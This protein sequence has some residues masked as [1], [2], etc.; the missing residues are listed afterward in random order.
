[1]SSR[2]TI[3]LVLAVWAVVA[4]V[5]AIYFATREAPTASPP[6]PSGSSV[7]PDH[8]AGPAPGRR[9]PEGSGQLG[10]LLKLALDKPKKSEDDRPI[11]D[12]LK[13]LLDK[14]NALAGSDDWTV[15]KSVALHR[16]VYSLIAFDTDAHLALMDLLRTAGSGDEV[17]RVLE[18]LVWSPFAKMTR[19]DKVTEE[20]TEQ[21]RTMLAT[22]PDAVRRAGAV[23]ALYRYDRPTRE[24]VLFGLDRLAEETDVEVRDVLLE[25]IT[26]AGLEIGLTRGEAEPFVQALRS[27]LGD[28]ELWC[29]NALAAWSDSADDFRWIKQR[30][31]QERD[32]NRRQPFLNAFHSGSAMVRGRERE[33]KAVLLSILADPSA[34][35]SHRSMAQSFLQSYGPLDADAAAAARSF[36]AE[37]KRR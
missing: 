8:R 26:V 9:M 31:E 11:G 36:E 7:V 5:A 33:A 35:E 21:A 2:K 4:S 13:A 30:V 23:R 19:H 15:D 22:D 25:E 34:H 3:P 32:F 20:I 17:H 28:G 10:A 18:F 37:R 16:Q 24:D 12:R 1:M 6:K 14:M 27:R 29:A